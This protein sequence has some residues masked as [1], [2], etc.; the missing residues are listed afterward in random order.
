MS[1]DSKS[2]P[3]DFCKSWRDTEVKVGSWLSKGFPEETGSEI[4]LGVIKEDCYG[5]NGGL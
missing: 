5:I 2:A 1:W 4:V 3:S